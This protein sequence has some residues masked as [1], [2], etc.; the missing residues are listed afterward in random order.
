MKTMNR[1]IPVAAALAAM[2]GAPRDAQAQY[3]DLRITEAMSSSGTGGTVDWFEV[4]NYGL[5]LASLSGWTVDDSSF[6]F[7]NSAVLGGVT[8]LAAGESAI[9]LE[10]AAGADIA[11]FRA[12]WGGIDGV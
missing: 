6:S 8:S 12:F 10:S 4:T 3:S 2:L 9:F 5:T 7:A 1:L 11:S